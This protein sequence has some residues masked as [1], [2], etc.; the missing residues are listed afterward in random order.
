MAAVLDISI[1]VDQIAPFSL[2]RGL[3]CQ[4][5][6]QCLMGGDIISLLFNTV[7]LLFSSR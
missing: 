3:F 4:S 2:P 7:L 5:Y 6:V 1:A